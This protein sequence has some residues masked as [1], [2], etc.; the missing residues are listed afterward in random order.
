MD[1]GYTCRN[2]PYRLV[3]GSKACVVPLARIAS[4]WRWVWNEM[5]N[6]QQPCDVAI[7]GWRQGAAAGFPELAHGDCAAETCGAV[8]AGAAAGAVGAELPGECLE[9][10][11][12]GPVRAAQIREQGL[13][14]DPAGFVDP[15]REAS[16]SEVWLACAPSP[17]RC[18]D[19]TPVTVVVKR[20]WHALVCY[21]IKARTDGRSAWTATCARW[22]IA[23]ARSIACRTWRGWRPKEGRLKHALS[24]KKRGSRRRARRRVARES[25]KLANA[26]HAPCV[27]ASGGEGD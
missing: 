17:G 24:R 2:M 23:R 7:A 10:V 21:R 16:G 13:V 14:H 6:L 9:G 27:A 4:A 15:G 3:P 5:L 11:L 22:R 19:G 18:P 1:E 25:R 20:G 26:R 8:A 12:R